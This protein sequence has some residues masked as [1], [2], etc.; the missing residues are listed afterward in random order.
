MTTPPNR[1]PEGIP[2]G[3]QFAPSNHAEPDVSLPSATS[4]PV[5]TAS[6]DL[7]QWQNDYAVTY[8]TVTFDAGPILAR[9]SPE[10]RAQVEDCSETADDLYFEAVRR[11]LVEDHNGPFALSVRS[12][13]DEAE[14]QDPEVWDKIAAVPQ[15][16]KA[17]AVL[18]T[19]LTPFEIGARA[20]ENGWVEGLATFNMD[21]LIE[22]DLDGHGDQ[23]GK[24]LVGSELLM[25]VSARPVSVTP[26]GSIVCRLSGDA[27]AVV[28]G[29]DEDEMASY[30]AGRAEAD[31]TP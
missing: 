9:M 30:E 1:Q 11:G 12:A 3:G 17:E 19:P 25:D 6:V 5:V 31:Q 7:Q 20:D 28:D 15:A 14:E 23:I 29:F 24:K 18:D 21:D 4:A 13:M 2:A 16:R 22:S 10:E 8:E 27:S 26:D